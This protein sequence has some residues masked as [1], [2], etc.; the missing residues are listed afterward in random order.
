MNLMVHINIFRFF[1]SSNLVLPYK[2][3]LIR[4]LSLTVEK[5]GNILFKIIEMEVHEKV[6]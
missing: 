6:C 5:N 3:K 4:L 1:V 2:D